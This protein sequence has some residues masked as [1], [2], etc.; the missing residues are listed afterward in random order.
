[1]AHARF[2]QAN[3]NWRREVTDM[4]IAHMQ[5]ILRPEYLRHPDLHHHL[6]RL[7]QPVPEYTCPTCRKRVNQ[8]PVE[9]YALKSLVRTI[10]A[11]DKEEGV[12]IPPDRSSM[13]QFGRFTDPWSSYF[14]YTREH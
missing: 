7:Q 6:Q 9:V 11:A 1:M 14:Y 5:T 10:S 2:I 4:C 12:D 13:D 8:R 3:P